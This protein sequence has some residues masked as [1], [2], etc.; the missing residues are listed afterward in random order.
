MTEHGIAPID[1]LVSN[2]YPF[3][4]T[5]K[6]GGSI[7]DCIENIDIGGPAMVRA[8]A[9][10]FAHVG[11][12]V[13][14]R[15]YDEVLA[16]PTMPGAQWFTG[17]TVNFAE[18]LLNQGEPG[19]VALVVADE[20]GQSTSWTRERLRDEAGAL[21]ATLKAAGVGRGDVVV[22]YLPH[23]AETIVAFA[24]TA[25]LGAIWSGVGQDYVADAAIDRSTGTG[26]SAASSFSISFCIRSPESVF[27]CSLAS[28]HA[29]KPASSISPTPYH[30]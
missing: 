25:S 10:N 20:S 28:A 4:A 16:D 19:D 11:V 26:A 6:S 24:A 21:A 22:G 23:I 7:N 1:L 3:E 14:P 18:H 2:L 27:I 5:V 9:K 8:A 13:D 30:A 29:R 12:V 17:A 15:D